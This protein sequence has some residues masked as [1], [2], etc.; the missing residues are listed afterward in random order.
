MNLTVG[1]V[2][3]GFAQLLCHGKA[4]SNGN[5]RCFSIAFGERVNAPAAEE[6]HRLF[7]NGKHFGILALNLLLHQL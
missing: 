2:A 5:L 6:I 7:A 1:S 3:E 4:I